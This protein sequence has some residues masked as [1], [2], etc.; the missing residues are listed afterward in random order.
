MSL[1]VHSNSEYTCTLPCKIF[2][3]YCIVFMEDV[4]C[5]FSLGVWHTGKNIPPFP[6]LLVV[7]LNYSESCSLSGFGFVFYPLLRLL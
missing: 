7:L 1:H 4:L 6:F 2:A 3:L 5:L